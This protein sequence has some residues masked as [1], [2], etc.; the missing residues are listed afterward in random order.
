MLPG[1]SANTLAIVVGLGTA[2]IA[3]LAAWVTTVPHGEL[4]IWVR[5]ALF[6]S[7]SVFLG[8]ALATA[9]A[10]ILAWRRIRPQSLWWM[11]GGGL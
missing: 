10:G 5:P 3:L 6:V 2:G 9:F 7:A 8:L 1:F 4:S 11:A